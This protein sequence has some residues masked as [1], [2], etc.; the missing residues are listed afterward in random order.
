MHLSTIAV[1]V[2]PA[3]HVECSWNDFL[4]PNVGGTTQWQLRITQGY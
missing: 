3:I 4:S 1:S 2:P